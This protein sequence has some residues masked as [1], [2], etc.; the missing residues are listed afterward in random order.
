MQLGE[1]LYRTMRLRHLSASGDDRYERSD[2]PYPSGGACYELELY[3]LVNTCEGLSAGLYHY[4]PQTHQL[5][6]IADRTREV[7]VLLDGAYAA[8]DRQVKPQILLI[9]A[10]RF[11]RVTWK[12]STIAYALILKHVGVL[13]QTMY[14]VATAMGLAPCALGSG[15]A[16]VFAVAADTDYYTETSVGEF[17]LGS[18][19][20]VDD[21]HGGPGDDDADT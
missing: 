21:P 2:R 14:L 16:D 12:Y 19:P 7:Q 9:L 10:A 3:V 20:G 17:I 13:Y 15:N 5:G 8:T 6:H 4:C 18:R 1:F 11:Q